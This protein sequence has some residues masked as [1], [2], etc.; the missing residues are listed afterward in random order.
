MINIK[1]CA[2]SD[3]ADSSLDGQ[4]AALH[5]N[6]IPYMEMRTVNG[7]NVTM[8]T[9]DEAKEIKEKLDANG[10]KV[11][12]I[13][14]PIGKVDINTDFDEYLKLV[15]HTCELANVLG[16]DKIR[17]F[18]FFNA[19]EEKEKVFDYLNKMVEVASAYGVHLYHENEKDIYGDTK[20]RVQEIMDNTKGLKYIYDPANYLQCG[21]SADDTLD[22]F[23]AKT[24]Y[25]HIKDVILKSGALVPAGM[26]DGKIDE[27]V[28]RITEDKTLT[29]E[30]HL[31]VFEGYSHIDKT[32]M[33]HEV[34]FK[35]ATEAF[36]VAVSAI[37]AILVGAG[38][39]EVGDGFVK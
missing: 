20:E 3:E 6:N 19:Y 5:R 11:W 1:L 30:P 25:F 35:T 36:D 15:K 14:S 12:S 39:K 28:A 31:A 29:L 18:S 21:E 13:G 8:L 10:I 33:K 17:M 23:H 27:L 9:I 24:D 26:G 38:Y 22:M 4:I 2:F 37:K 32:V 16:T 7:K 34:V